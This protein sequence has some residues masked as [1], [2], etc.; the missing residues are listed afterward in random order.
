MF[1]YIRQKLYERRIIRERKEFLRMQVHQITKHFPWTLYKTIIATASALGGSER[2]LAHVPSDA[3]KIGEKLNNME[4]RITGKIE[5]RTGT[6][7]YYAARIDD[8][9]CLLGSSALTVGAQV[10]SSARLYV[11]NMTLTDKWITEVKRVD[12]DSGN[13]MSRLVFD[14]SGYDIIFAIIDFTAGAP[15]NDWQ[16]EFSGF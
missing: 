8:D 13:G 15:A 1:P 3:Y 2:T 4:V 12:A 10:S 6:V 11:D 5:D 7:Y 16:I 9:I 14:V